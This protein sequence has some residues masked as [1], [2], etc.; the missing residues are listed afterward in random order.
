[1]DKGAV[2]Y[3]CEFCEKHG[4][5]SVVFYTLHSLRI[6]LSKVHRGAVG[7]DPRPHCPEKKVYA[8]PN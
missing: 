8:L 7:L 6:H 5:V 1:M 3:S 2:E 4:G